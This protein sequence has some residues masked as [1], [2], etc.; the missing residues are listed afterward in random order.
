MRTR[1]SCVI[2]TI[3]AFFI[4]TFPFPAGAVVHWTNRT[5][6]SLGPGPAGA[7]DDYVTLAPNV[8]KDGET[9]KMWYTGKG[10]AGPNQ[11]G[12]ATS[13]DGVTWAK[14]AANPI[15]IP[16]DVGTWD[17]LA[18]QDVN[19]C[20]V[21]KTGSNYEMW[22]SAATVADKAQIGYATSSD[23]II[24]SHHGSPVLT[25]GPAGDWDASSVFDPAVIK[26]GSTYRMW[27][28]GHGAGQPGIGYATGQSG[29]IH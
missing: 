9:Y 29:I 7:W 26:D 17:G 1:S 28:T 12:Y 3:L 24:W 10:S 6:T 5:E 20:V 8:I 13:S 21:I 2:F 15:I 14:H 22:Y 16:A 18:V 27:Y 4:L 19:Q 11:I 25:K 23:G